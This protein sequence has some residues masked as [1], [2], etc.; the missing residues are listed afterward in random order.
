MCENGPGAYFWYFAVLLCASY[1]WWF[2]I[3]YP[4]FILQYPKQ[5]K[6]M[7]SHGEFSL[8]SLAV[9]PCFND[10]TLR[11]YKAAYN[12][13]NPSPKVPFDVNVFIIQAQFRLGLIFLN[14]SYGTL[15]RCHGEVHVQVLYQ[16]EMWDWDSYFVQQV[17]IVQKRYEWGIN[18][19]NDRSIISVAVSRLGYSCPLILDN[20]CDGFMCHVVV[21]THNRCTI[22]GNAWCKGKVFVNASWHCVMN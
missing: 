8:W 14:G 19:H 1:L 22:W 12:E 16:T 15:T 20:A 5:I 7:L 13:S 2:C 10:V 21:A 17:E 11:Y 18:E 4:S 3:S 6:K 9:I